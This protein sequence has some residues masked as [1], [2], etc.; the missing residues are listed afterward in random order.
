MVDNCSY[1]HQPRVSP[2]QA[3]LS[4]DI[5]SI[6]LRLFQ[7]RLSASST[8]SETQISSLLRELEGFLMALLSPKDISSANPADICRFF[9]WKKIRQNSGSFRRVLIPR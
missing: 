3:S 2:S 6:D 8:S 7:L 5:V 4:V 9:V 1:Q